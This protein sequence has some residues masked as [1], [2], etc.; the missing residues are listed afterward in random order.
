MSMI[1]SSAPQGTEEW[2]A[3]RRGVITASR[4]KDARDR[5]KSGDFSSKAKLYAQDVARERCGGQAGQTFQNAA[6]RFGTEQEPVARMACE[7]EKGYLIELAG[8]AYTEDRKFG[9]S[10]DG[11]IDHDGVWECKTM[12]SSETLF[13][14]VV[15]GDIGDYRDQINGAMWLL[16]RKWVDLCL[17]AP[18]LPSHKL[19]LI[20]VKRDDD[21]IE[22][23]E[24]D[25]MA[26]EKLVSQYEAK[27][28]KLLGTGDEPAPA[29]ATEPPP[30]AASPAPAP[31]EL[32][33][34]AF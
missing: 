1:W 9:V 5:L 32:V 33:A 22:A 6:M 12:V 26:F 30:W 21:A 18:D 13:K 27:L 29:S 20:R 2:L 17:W 14:A 28:R 4:F 34:P 8:F 23:L 19:T 11:L 16:G 25:L 10:V 7:D 15:D 24:S 31:S 3:A